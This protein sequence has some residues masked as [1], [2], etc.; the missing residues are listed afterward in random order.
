LETELTTG[1]V[2]LAFDTAET[3]Q[4]FW[5]ISDGTLSMGT[6]PN[7][8]GSYMSY[9][10]SDRLCKILGKNDSMP[11]NTRKSLRAANEKITKFLTD[12][13]K[14]FGQTLTWV[15]TH[16]DI[17]DG[18]KAAGKTQDFLF[19]IGDTIS[20]YA[21]ALSLAFTKFCKDNDN[22]EALQEVLTSGKIGLRFADPAKTADEFWV[23]ADG[24]LWMEAKPNYFGS[25]MSY[26]DSDRLEKML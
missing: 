5:I 14:L 10:D 9:Y 18:L 7:Y 1:K 3:E 6:K 24:V 2:G 12:A 20:E 13:S 22:K 26:Y 4:N 15:D 23:L 21:K 19:T 8:F 11:L 16:Q 25:Y 17:Y